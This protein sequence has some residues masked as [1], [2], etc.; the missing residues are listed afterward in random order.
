[1]ITHSESLLERMR[2][3]DDGAFEECVRAYS[4][5]LLAVARRIVGNEEEAHHALQ[6]GFLSAFKNI[7]AFEG[8]AELGTWLHGIIVNAALIQLRRRRRHPERS[9]EDSLP[10][11]GEGEHQLIPPVL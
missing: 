8:R 5:R 4:T 2:A 3:G 7:G 1:M 6:D 9:I 10:D 11:F